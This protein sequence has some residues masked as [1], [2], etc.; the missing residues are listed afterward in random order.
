MMRMNLLINLIITVYIEEQRNNK[1]IAKRHISDTK[2]E[3][4]PLTT[5]AKT[6]KVKERILLQRE[7]KER[8][9]QAWSG[10]PTASNTAGCSYYK[11]HMGDFIDSMTIQRSPISSTKVQ[12]IMHSK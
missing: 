3:T 9:S 7:V 12:F 4:M 1:V 2:V 11:A 6:F 8:Q 10:S 5:S